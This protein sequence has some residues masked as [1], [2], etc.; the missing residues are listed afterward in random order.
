MTKKI[1]KT[2]VKALLWI[3]AAVAIVALIFI[4]Y[5]VYD[6]S[7]VVNTEYV[8]ESEKVGAAF[9]G[10]R[11]CLIT[12]FHNDSNYKKV[13]K[14]VEKA[15]PDII[16]IAG[17]LINMD[18]LDYNNAE[19][20]IKGLTLMGKVFYCYGNHE[21]ASGML[22]DKDAPPIEG[23]LKNSGVEFMNDRVYTIEKDGDKLNLIGY[24]DDI[25]DDFS[26]FFTQKME[27]RLK[28]LSKN[29]DRS[30]PSV[31]IMHR[32]QYFDIVSEYPFDLVLSGHLHGGLINIDGIREYILKEHFNTAQYCKGTYFKNGKE[33]VISGGLAREDKLFRVFNTPE[34]VTVEVR[35]K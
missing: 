12:D 8:F 13:L 26:P 28:A 6:N 33:L 25:Y 21:I 11:I 9:D 31:L 2:A 27:P 22:L 24:G 16:V 20:L 15:N 23:V 4:A 7:R 19:E 17:D 35:R 34:I 1:F 3:I 18:E 14:A 30:V 10:Y 32:P 5:V 29:L